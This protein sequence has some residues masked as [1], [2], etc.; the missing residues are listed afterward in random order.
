MSSKNKIL[1]PNIVLPPNLNAPKD[2]SPKACL[3]PR[4]FLVHLT[5]GMKAPKLSSSFSHK[6]GGIWWVE[7]RRIILLLGFTEGLFQ[8][9]C[10]VLPEGPQKYKPRKRFW[11]VLVKK[12]HFQKKSFENLLV[13]KLLDFIL[14]V[15][16]KFNYAKRV[17]R[18]AAL[19]YYRSFSPE[20]LQ[21]SSLD[22]ISY[23]CYFE[24]ATPKSILYKNCHSQCFQLWLLCG[25]TF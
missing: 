23:I 24:C 18:S 5:I 8:S 6:K 4:F 11:L 21:L 3:S 20:V 12:G 9:E 16:R 22:L 19:L 14:F 17:K 13:M 2:K 10:D 1:S 15:V 25:E 7:K